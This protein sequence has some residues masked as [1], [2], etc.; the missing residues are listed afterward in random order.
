MN[1]PLSLALAVTAAS[2]LHAAPILFDFGTADSPLHT[3]ALRVT[4]KGGEHAAWEFSVPPAARAH[5]VQR[6]WTE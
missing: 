5:P 1:T 2:A 4:E 3:G 6:D